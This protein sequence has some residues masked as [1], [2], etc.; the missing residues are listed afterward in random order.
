MLYPEIMLREKLKSW[1]STALLSFEEELRDFLAMIEGR[2]DVPLADGYAGLRSVE[3]AA[4]VRQSTLSRE[5]IRLPVLGRM[6]RP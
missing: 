1:H 6:G 2:T 5:V 4:A 3:I